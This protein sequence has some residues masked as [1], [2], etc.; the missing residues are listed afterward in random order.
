MNGTFISVTSGPN[1][2]SS[3]ST[4]SVFTK[5]FLACSR[6]SELYSLQLICLQQTMWEKY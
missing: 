2:I 5:T 1:N 4:K 3:F 6:C